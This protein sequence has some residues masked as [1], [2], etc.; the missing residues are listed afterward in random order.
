MDHHFEFTYDFPLWT[1]VS[2]ILISAGYWIIW[3]RSK[4][5]DKLEGTV[6]G[7][8]AAVDH[9]SW[10]YQNYHRASSEA[11]LQAVTHPSNRVAKLVEAEEYA[12][13]AIAAA[14]VQDQR[15]FT[16]KLLEAIVNERARLPGGE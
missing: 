4:R 13:K 14:T 6:Y 9:P 8:K 15:D 16:S 12:R 7:A 5:L 1:L 2:W 10:N 11:M 3:Q